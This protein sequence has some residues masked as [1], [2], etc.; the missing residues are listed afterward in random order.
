GPVYHRGTKADGG[1]GLTAGGR[2]LFVVGR[3]ATLAE[4]REKALA[5]VARIDCDN[6]F[7]RTDIGHW[8]LDDFAGH[9]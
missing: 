6:L 8:A 3:G 1:R 7:H 5:D 4:A 9:K 2:V